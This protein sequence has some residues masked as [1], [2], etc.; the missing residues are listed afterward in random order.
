MTEQS[1]SRAYVTPARRLENCAEQSPVKKQAPCKNRQLNP[2][3]NTRLKTQIDSILQND[4][5]VLSK[6]PETP[7]RALL[8]THNN[9]L[10]LHYVRNIYQ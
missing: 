5:A 9:P 7:H 2:T 10:I 3:S 1:P 4:L 6:H 8:T